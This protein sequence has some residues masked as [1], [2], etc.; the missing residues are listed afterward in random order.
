M[1]ILSTS[2][3]VLNRSSKAH[4][5]TWCSVSFCVVD[6]WQIGIDDLERRKAVCDFNEKK[7]TQVRSEA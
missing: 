1:S 4:L 3:I 5:N 6:S 7:E 2:I